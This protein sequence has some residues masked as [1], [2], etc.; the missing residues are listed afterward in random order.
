[1]L[2]GRYRL[3]QLLGRGGMGEVWRC[4]DLRLDRDV[5]VKVLLATDPDPDDVLRFRREAQAAA[6]LRH[7]GIPVVYDF[8]EAEGQMFIVSELL[9]GRDLAKLLKARPGGVPVSEAAG[10]CVEVAGALVH[11]HEQGIV[12]RDLK[13][14]N[15]FAQDDGPLKV[16]DFGIARDLNATSSLTGTGQTIGTPAYMAPEQWRAEPA[17]PAMD[18]YALGCVLYELLTGRPPF[19]G[20][21]LPAL[22]NQHVNEV[23]VPPRDRNPKIP[24]SLNELVLSLLAKVPGGRPRDADAIRAT[25]TQIRD[26]DQEPVAAIRATVA[27]VLDSTNEPPAAK[28]PEP[29]IACSGSPEGFDVL[30]LDGAGRLRHRGFQR[31][32]ADK[33]WRWWSWEEVPAPGGE[34]TAISVEGEIITAVADGVPRIAVRNHWRWRPLGGFPG[35]AL[36]MRDVAVLAPRAVALDADGH[37]LLKQSPLDGPAE[38]QLI[39]SG[40]MT[41]MAARHD[42]RRGDTLITAD[43]TDVVCAS[44]HDDEESLHWDQRIPLGRPIADVACAPVRPGHLVIFALDIAGR[45]WRGSEPFS[46]PRWTRVTGPSGRVTAI[47]ATG[48]SGTR[49][50]LLAA[51]GNGET[52]YA[53]QELSGSGRRKSWSGWSGWVAL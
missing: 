29:L 46:S 45:I 30:A 15:L 8:G 26:A 42:G 14:S 25:L 12:H 50:V 40:P 27:R 36:P 34:V 4:R 48:C 9:R 51:T 20:P 47:A 33:E 10:F 35:P 38:W 6:G 21:G 5:A 2:A 44:W 49:V 43:G 28:R 24:P 37:V 41:T 32:G 3:D 19:R 11:A 39:R 23:P 17:S 18:L 52:H 1:M 31:D 13:P 7:P 16:L 22:L 53:E